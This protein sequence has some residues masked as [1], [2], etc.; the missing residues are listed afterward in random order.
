[1]NNSNF[2]YR[3]I[4][5]LGFGFFGIS[6]LWPLYNAYVPIF[7]KD[8][9]L[10]SFVIGSIMT[11]DN[12][13]AILM[14]PYIGTLSDQTRTRIGRRKPY[15][16]AG[17]PFAALFFIMI[18]LAKNMNSLVLMMSVIIFMNFAMAL[19]RSPVIALMPDITPSKFRSQANGVINFMGGLGALFAYFAGKPLY[20]AN[21]AYPFIFGAV[22]MLGANS[23]ILLFV[24]E[25]EEYTVKNSRPISVFETLKRANAELL[26]NLKDA[27]RSK[28]KSLLLI[29]L[30]ILFWFI[31]FNALETFFTS[32]AKFHLG[33]PESTGALVLG[34]FSLAFMLTAVPAG[35]IGSK[36]GR[37][38]TILLGLSILITCLI[39][40]VAIVNFS[41]KSLLNSLFILFA[42][43]GLGWA[44]VN[45]NSL[46]MVVD[47]TDQEKVGGYTGL[48][49]FFSMAA[50]IFA[51]PLAG[52][53][54]DLAGYNSLVPFSIA[55]VI[56]SAFTMLFVKRGEVTR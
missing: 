25:P 12:L 15:I 45:V 36:L 8:F 56:L 6:A 35:L 19:F 47:M 7:L 31:G 46:P 53:F 39:T 29:L 54:I 14:L 28:E 40:V 3:K 26:G 11:I 49:Y 10:S 33:I 42:I 17:A 30:S 4:F 44:L 43:S 16:L 48:Y 24:K 51:P 20:D 52:A 23:L 9:K 50:N 34:V 32:Y 22:L 18:P 41:S 2:S 1:M 38:R 55:F 21:Y 37:K 13:F 5:L 27:F